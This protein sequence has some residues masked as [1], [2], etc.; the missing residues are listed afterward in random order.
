MF[1]LPDV[2]DIGILCVFPDPCHDNSRMLYCDSRYNMEE[3]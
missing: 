1:Y 3:K 2:Y